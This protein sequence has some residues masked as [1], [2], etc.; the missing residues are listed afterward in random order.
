MRTKLPEPWVEAAHRLELD[1]WTVQCRRVWLAEARRGTHVQQGVGDTRETALE[2]LTQ[3]TLLD[4][5][6]GYG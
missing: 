6:E 4:G 3:M 2:E 1:G 5:P